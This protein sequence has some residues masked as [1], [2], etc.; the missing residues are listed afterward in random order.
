MLTG[1]GGNAYRY[2]G[3]GIRQEKITAEGVVHRY[4]TSGGRI[5]GEEIVEN[6]STNTYRY[7]YVGDQVVGLVKNNSQKYY[8]QYN[9]TGDVSKICDAAGEIAASYV[10][11]AWGNHRIYDGTGVEVRP[12]FIICS[13]GTMT[14]RSGGLSM[15]TTSALCRRTT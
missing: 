4:Y 5:L 12:G 1:Y 2:D 14:R 8:F 11:D 15:R 13:P 3:N 9:A 10:Y 7:L 6:G